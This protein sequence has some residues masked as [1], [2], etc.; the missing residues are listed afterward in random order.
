MD[1]YPVVIHIQRG[2][3]VAPN[4]L[5]VQPKVEEY[6]FEVRTLTRR[7][8]RR[9]TGEQLELL[10][11]QDHL[12][13]HAVV[14][15]PATFHGAPW[16]WDRVYAGVVDQLLDEILWLSGFGP[17]GRGP[18]PLITQHAHAY[19]GDGQSNYDL[20]ILCAFDAYKL[21]DLFDMHPEDWQK[22]AGQAQRKL[23]L[24]GLDPEAILDPEGYADRMKKERRKRQNQVQGG[25][26][27]AQMNWG[28]GARQQ[29][30]SEGGMSFGDMG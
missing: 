26:N 6:R 11:F 17:D 23:Y 25:Q 19:L 8:Y 7:E 13:E 4:G 14:R 15:H 29:T 27:P 22:L 5:T 28:P 21:E 20:M 18:H 16:D 30:M 24:L 3:E 2:W 9:W 10:Q 12:L 1:S